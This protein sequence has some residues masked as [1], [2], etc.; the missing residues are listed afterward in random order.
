MGLSGKQVSRT[1]SRKSVR[2][3]F[4]A[5]TVFLWTHAVASVKTALVGG[6]GRHRQPKNMKT[7]TKPTLLEIACAF[8]HWSEYLDVDGHIDEHEFAV[9][10]PVG[11]LAQIQECGYSE[12][13]RGDMYDSTG[14]VIAENLAIQIEAASCVSDVPTIVIGGIVYQTREFRE[15]TSDT[16]VGSGGWYVVVLSTEGGAE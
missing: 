2:K 7:E 14:H 15:I 13:Y 1:E 10:D 8:N 5:S 4:W 12:S 11:R 16:L 6:G 3:K 9:A